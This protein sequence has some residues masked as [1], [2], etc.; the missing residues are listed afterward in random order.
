MPRRLPIESAQPVVV[1]AG[2]RLALAVVGMIVL[3][4][5]SYPDGA[6]EAVG[7]ACFIA[8]SLG[9]LLLALRRPRAALGPAVIAGDLLV[10]LAVEL[11]APEAARGVRSA[12]L[13]L[14]AGHAHFQGE[15][16]GVALAVVWVLVLVPASAIRG[17]G[18]EDEAVA[19]HEALFALAAVSTGAVVGRLRTYESA[20]RIRARELSRRTMR[21][22]GQVRRR[23]ANAIHDGPVQELIGL[24]MILSTLGSEMG[25]GGGELANDL[26][27]SARELTERNIQAL[28]DE[29]VD[30]G[31]HG[32]EQLSLERAV[33][34]CVPVWRRRYGL[35][36][37]VDLDSVAL[38]SEMEGE[39]FRIVQ[40]AVVNAGRHGRASRVVVRS[41]VAG[42]RLELSIADDGEGFGPVD[43]WRDAEPGHLGLASMRERTE[44]L[45]GELDIAS[46][47]RGTTVTVSFR[48]RDQAAGAGWFRLRSS[49]RKANEA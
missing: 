42:D 17:G 40:E 46:S 37:E 3:A 16:R 26:L 24:D 22:E 13:F 8:W 10:L 9:V 30:L 34:D 49:S 36:V 28:R 18:I 6:G 44:L 11:L 19:F 31:P 1:F 23:V 4:V 48:L 47:S 35:S 7:G 12:A 38:P 5:L 41:R 2:A 15:R 32:V 20:S 29:L 25:R 27:R 21:S 45:D 43:P 33:E 39:L 14:I